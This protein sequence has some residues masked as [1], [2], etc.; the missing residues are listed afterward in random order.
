MHKLQVEKFL[1][2]VNM[3]FSQG[4]LYQGEI[5]I[6]IAEA[7]YHYLV[8]NIEKFSHT[9]PLNSKQNKSFKHIST[10]AITT[11][12]KQI[13]TN[14]FSQMQTQ[15]CHVPLALTLLS[16]KTQQQYAIV[17]SSDHGYLDAQSANHLYGLL[18]N[19]YNALTQNDTSSLAQ[20]ITQTQQLTTY[21]ANEFLQHTQNELTPEQHKHNQQNIETYPFHHSPINQIDQEIFKTYSATKQIPYI[22]EYN[23][24]TFINQHRS[25][26][27]NQHLTKN[28]LICAAI[29]K[30]Y[31][32]TNQV[33]K[34]TFAMAISLATETQ[35]Q[36]CLGNYVLTV[37]VSVNTQQ[38]SVAEIAEQIQTRITQCKQDKEQISRFLGRERHLT[39]PLKPVQDPI[40]YYVTNWT[41]QN[42][43]RNKITPHNSQFLKQIG[44]LNAQPKSLTESSYI[45]K[46]G[47]VI[48]L[49]PNNQLTLSLTPSISGTTLLETVLESIEL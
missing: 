5:D 38:A 2:Q 31:A 27:Q 21:S 1:S 9:T 29:A 41:N 45:S 25:Q 42:T 12:F 8:D 30:S 26:A 46:Q 35:R 6:S 23:L 40:A 15:L 19:I 39:E 44:A 10:K 32:K 14:A 18:I 13:S 16:D 28:N 36:T 22:R 11:E 7:S 43:L 33:D 20:L 49:S 34:L 48:N 17:F 4:Y 24:N 47:I 3:I 37:P